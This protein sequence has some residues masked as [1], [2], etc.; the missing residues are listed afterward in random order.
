MYKQSVQLIVDKCIGCTNCIKRCPTEAIRVQNGKA[1][2]ISDRCLDCGECIRVCQSNAKI[3]ISDPLS[4]ID[5]YDYKIAIP[6]PSLYGIAD[7]HISTD[8]I[9]TG[10]KYLGFDD[11]FE[12]ASAAEII[13]KRTN[14]FLSRNEGRGP[15][16][17]SSCPAVVRLVQV[18]F[19]SLID[20]II[21]FISPMELAAQ[22][23]RNRAGS[24]KGKVGVFFIS[25][26]AAKY[27]EI[28]DPHR[29]E[30]SAVDAVIGI[31]DIQVSLQRLIASDMETE[32]LAMASG[33][34]IG[35]GRIDGE[36]RAL[37]TEG[38]ISVDGISNVIALLEELENGKIDQFRFIELMACPGGC[39]GGPMTL[40]NPYV[41]KSIILE[42]WDRKEG[43][44]CEECGPMKD[45]RWTEELTSCN[46]MKLDD[47]YEKAMM[48][49]QRLE[50]IEKNLPG[51]DCGSC[52]AP[53]CHA[54]AEDIVRGR[55]EITS[56]IFV[57]RKKIRQLTDEMIKLEDALPY[58]L[59]KNE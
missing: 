25:P 57:L 18:R 55:N 16:I 53:T 54:F 2:I 31:K 40:V 59:D 21:P 44:V 26:C 17:S 11:V 32:K 5:D 56:C 27:S 8:R 7:S 34:G 35:W 42:R 41:A 23:A 3:A 15:F 47:D 4:V 30:K 1:Q 45:I 48:M 49:L 6:A 33:A 28:R 36:A 43:V 51:I 13:T 37:A 9:L 46:F 38:V 39:V 50:L 29:K 58:R 24:D 19:P 22:I 14:E 52:G 20:H 10:L 12:V